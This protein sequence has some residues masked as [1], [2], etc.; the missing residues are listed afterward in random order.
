MEDA[1]K[2]RS[3]NLSPIGGKVAQESIVTVVGNISPQDVEDGTV[4]IF[5]LDIDKIPNKAVHKVVEQIQK[6]VAETFE[7]KLKAMIVPNYI[8]VQTLRDILVDASERSE[9]EQ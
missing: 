7:G 5:S 2:I 3:V 1:N 9:D 4:L 8:E 6:A